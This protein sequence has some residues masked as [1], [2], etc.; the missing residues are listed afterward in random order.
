MEYF[1]RTIK[2]ISLD[3]TINKIKELST[4]KDVF[5]EMGEPLLVDKQQI[6]VF[7]FFKKELAGF[8]CYNSNTIL[9]VYTLPKFRE[10]GLF[11]I[12]YNELPF[13]DWKVIASNK[14]LN[15]FKRKGFKVVKNYKNC[16]KLELKIKNH[17][18]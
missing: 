11:T 6:W 15:L 1:F 7:A 18:K 8:I 5:K 9:Y 3:Y 17:L 12:L 4:S 14:S 2:S 16:H 13:Q 10:K